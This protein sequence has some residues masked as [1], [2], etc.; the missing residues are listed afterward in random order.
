MDHQPAASPAFIHAGLQVR[1][2]EAQS[3]LDPGHPD[4]CA[5]CCIGSFLAEYH[6]PSGF[7]V[8]LLWCCACG[9]GGSPL[10][11]W[12]VSGVHR[13]FAQRTE[14]ERAMQDHL[15]LEPACAVLRGPEAHRRCGIYANARLGISCEI[16]EVP[17][18]LPCSWAKRVRFCVG[19]P[20]L[21]SLCY[22][23][24][25]ETS[26]TTQRQP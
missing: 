2:A 25:S 10:R 4:P 7:K 12:R 6:P 21:T 26:R 1:A 18:R 23:S 14:Q 16:P 13:R 22:A 24:R 20:C 9:A 17:G 3:R 15:L 5:R 19:A 8:Q 11:C